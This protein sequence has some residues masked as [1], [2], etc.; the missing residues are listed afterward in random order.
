MTGTSGSWMKPSGKKS[1]PFGQGLFKSSKVNVLEL[2]SL[3]TFL[4]LPR[5]FIFL[6]LNSSQG[7]CGGDMW[8]HLLSNDDDIEDG[9]W[10]PRWTREED[11][12]EL[13]YKTA[14]E[15]SR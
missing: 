6:I 2:D 11:P 15:S 3:L 9:P 5:S 10:G 7:I 8:D 4:V 12:V 13:H 1:S 14:I